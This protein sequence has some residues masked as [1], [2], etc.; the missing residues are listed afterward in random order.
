MRKLTKILSYSFAAVTLVTAS[1]ATPAYAAGCSTSA[2]TTAAGWQK[3]VVDTPFNGRWYHGDAGRSVRLPDGRYLWV[4]GDTMSGK[5]TNGTQEWGNQFIHNRAVITDKGCIS[6]LI[7][8]NRTDGHPTDWI[9]ITKG[10]DL[11]GID[12]YYWPSGMYMD[13]AYLRMFLN[14]VGGGADY[15]S[16]GVDV[17]TF[18]VSRATPRL[19]SISRTPAAT[20]Q[21]PAW[22]SAVIN[23]G[24][25][26]YIYGGINKSEP[27]VWGH[28]HYLARVPRGSVTTKSSWRYW[29]G[30]GWT[31]QQ[32]QAVPVI[33]GNQ[34]V[35]AGT[36]MFPRAGGGYALIAKQYEYVGSELVAFTS[37]SVTGPWTAQSPAVLS[38]VPDV[39][40]NEVT[41]SAFA[42]PGIALTSGKTLVSWALSS[43][44]SSQFGSPRPGLRFTEVVMP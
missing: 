6:Q 40:A 11:A 1:L 2:P 13:G 9:P 44:D 3:L 27:W 25:Y 29:N 37:N 15:S 39:Q 16:H 10:N 7:G 8:P 20:A 31:T 5:V 24:L 4:F 42:H 41:Y 17:A 34:G 30:T 33:N 14:H 28:Y 19:V 18:D 32:A 23:D 43:T 38:P 26:T 35:G 12:D 21:D 22:G 36:V